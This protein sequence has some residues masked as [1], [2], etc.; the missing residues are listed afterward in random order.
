MLT[1]GMSGY[2]GLG[3]CLILIAWL[4]G[5]GMS[6]NAQAQSDRTT[7]CQRLWPSDPDT[8]SLCQNLENRNRRE[9]VAYLTSHG[10]TRHNLDTRAEAG[11]RA[12]EVARTC[13]ARWRPK[14]QAV[15]RCTR[16]AN[17]RRASD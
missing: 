8:L 1:K 13:L 2:G 11:D 12:A 9:F 3:A 16:T 7:H 14:Y 17:E 15:W 4:A 5:T 6:G 10:L